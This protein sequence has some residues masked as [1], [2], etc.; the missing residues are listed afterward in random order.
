MWGWKELAN[1]TVALSANNFIAYAK[2]VTLS[3]SVDIIF[4]HMQSMKA[5]PTYLKFRDR[6]VKV[7][8]ILMELTEW[9]KKE[10]YCHILQHQ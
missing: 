1:Q 8:D 10:R 3:Y 4:S 2:S 9:L 5:S 7:H 6:Q